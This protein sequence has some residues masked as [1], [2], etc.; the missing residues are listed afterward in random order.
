MVV[1]TTQWVTVLNMVVGEEP[2][3]EQEPIMDWLV[4]AHSLVVVLEAVVD[5]RPLERVGQEVH[6]VAL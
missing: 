3:V 4:E 6:Q 5:V 2:A 1:T